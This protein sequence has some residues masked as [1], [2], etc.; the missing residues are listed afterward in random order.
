MGHPAEDMIA[1]KE[2]A[3]TDTQA[4]ETNT[5]EAVEVTEETE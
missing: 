4:T 3:T 5:K 2:E 1:P